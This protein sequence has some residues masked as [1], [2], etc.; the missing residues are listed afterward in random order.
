MIGTKFIAF[1][2]NMQ[3]IVEQSAF[4]GYMYKNNIEIVND[5]EEKQLSEM[6]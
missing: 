2:N 4:S 3:D 6:V 1:R 5:A